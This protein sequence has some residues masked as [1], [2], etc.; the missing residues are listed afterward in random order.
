MTIII[1]NYNP[2]WPQEFEA[3]KETL[4]QVLGPFALRIDHIGSTSV[5]G[6]GAKDVIDIQIRVHEL[7]SEIRDMLVAAGYEY[8]ESHTHDHAP[9]GED[10]DPSLWAKLVFSEPIGQRRANVH[11]RIDGNPDQRY[12]WCFVTTCGR[13]Q[14]RRGRSS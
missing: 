7:T 11:V 4:A 1:Q 5:P 12:A 13:I 3:I 2:T 10:D 9:L 8:A 6:L 14:T